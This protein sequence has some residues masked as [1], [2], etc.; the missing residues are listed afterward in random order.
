MGGEKLLEPLT[1]STF[2]NPPVLLD[3]TSQ[4]GPERSRILKRGLEDYCSDRIQFT[5]AGRESV[6]QSLEGNRPTA[7]ERITQC[8][9][10]LPPDCLQQIA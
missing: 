9:C 3:L 1:Y 10:S 8:E 2:E 4:A 5:S 7:R 6:A